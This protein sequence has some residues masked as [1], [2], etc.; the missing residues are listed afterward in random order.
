MIQPNT[1]VRYALERDPGDLDNL[2]P[3]GAVG[4]TCWRDRESGN[5][6]VRWQGRISCYVGEEEI[7]EMTEDEKKLF[8]V[9]TVM[10]S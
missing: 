10:E 6:F 8:L 3:F 9:R 4:V 7:R 1:M 5:Y 2:I